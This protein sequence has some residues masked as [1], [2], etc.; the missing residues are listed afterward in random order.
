M[1]AALEAAQT[2]AAPPEARSYTVGLPVTLTVHPDGTVTYDVDL[3][4]ASD[5]EDGQPLDWTTCEHPGCHTSPTPLYTEE[6]VAAD[7][8][9]ISAAL[10]DGTVQP[11]DTVDVRYAPAVT[12][13]VTVPLHV[14]GLADGCSVAAVLGDVRESLEAAGGRFALSH[15]GVTFTLHS[16]GRGRGS[17]EGTSVTDAVTIPP[18]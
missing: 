2:P 17:D 12:V 15:P 10:D 11:A 5:I 6:E 18:A 14:Q 8:E 16:V 9:V 1:S 3:S 7:A 4:E 13:T